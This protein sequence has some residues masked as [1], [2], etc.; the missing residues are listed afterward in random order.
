MLPTA[1]QPLNQAKTLFAGIVLVG[2]LLLLPARHPRR[3]HGAIARRTRRTASSGRPAAR[4]C[5]GSSAPRMTGSTGLRALVDPRAAQGVRRRASRSTTSR[6]TFRPGTLTALIGPNGA[7][8][9]TLF[10]LLTNLYRSDAGHESRSSARRSPG[11]ERRDRAP[12]PRAHVSDGARLPRDDGRSRTCWPGCTSRRAHRSGRS[13]RAWR[14]RAGRSASL[15][16]RAEALLDAVGLARASATATR[17]RCRWA[18]RRSSS[19]RAR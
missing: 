7:G 5:A 2:G 18:A 4:H 3:H 1:I 14:P 13:V 6:S 12:R 9:S 16:Q 17:R 15:T 8:K 10:N 11:S 19:S